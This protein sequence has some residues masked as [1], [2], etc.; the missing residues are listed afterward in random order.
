MAETLTATTPET[1]PTDGQEKRPLYERAS[2]ARARGDTEA[3]AALQAEVDAHFFAPRKKS[4]RRIYVDVTAEPDTSPVF[5][6]KYLA[7]LGRERRAA[8][9]MEAL[10]DD[11][12]RS[13][14][15][16]MA[17]E[18][19]E[20]PRGTT[21]LEHTTLAP[22][23]DLDVIYTNTGNMAE[24]VTISEEDGETHAVQAHSIEIARLA[25]DEGE[26]RI[27][28]DG[29]E[30]NQDETEVAIKVLAHLQ[31]SLAPE[32][33]QPQEAMGMENA[34]AAE[35]VT[36]PEGESESEPNPEVETISLPSP[37]SPSQP[38]DETVPSMPTE[39]MPIEQSSVA[40]K[41]IM[42]SQEDQY[43]RHS[44]QFFQA[45]ARHNG[46]R[47]AVLDSLVAAGIDQVAFESAVRSGNGVDRPLLEEMQR[48]YR[49]Y[50]PESPIWQESEQSPSMMGRVAKDAKMRLRRIVE[51]IS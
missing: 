46:T 36:E 5:S 29:H 48:L 39:D 51:Q 24:S 12:R 6:E 25:G 9:F 45:M 16:A 41:T 35:I 10:A 4:E 13:G 27:M 7:D 32:S 40:E 42:A 38:T 47:Q 23:I 21:G 18:V 28:I 50:P 14:P 44:T 3:L 22:G 19:I 20:T 34:V 26:E 49:D 8:A 11:A 31:E 43:R 33:D 2:E 15:Y 37:E 1:S 30:P 17:T